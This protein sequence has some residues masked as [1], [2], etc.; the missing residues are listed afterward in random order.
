MKTVFNSYHKLIQAWIQQAIPNGRMTKGISMYSG[1]KIVRMFFEGESLYS[2]GRH[3]EMARIV[4]GGDV[5]LVNNNNYSNTT[6]KHKHQL[7]RELHGRGLRIY[8]VD[9][10]GYN[11]YNV[12]DYKQRIE[13]LLSRA[14]RCRATWMFRTLMASARG[15]VDEA[16][17]YI[18]E[19]DLE[20]D[21][22][23]QWL[24]KY[25]DNMLIDKGM[26]IV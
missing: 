12:V 5:V 21:E 11:H 4:K 20:P 22:R 14:Y 23:I 6:Q 15:L 16:D 7:D 2:Y 18:K 9:Q 1:E 3:Y 25:Q 13:A 26:I 10:I 19:F 8:S 24:M 17:A